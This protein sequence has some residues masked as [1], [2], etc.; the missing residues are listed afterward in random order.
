MPRLTRAALRSQELKEDPASIPLPVTPTKG[1]VPLK[2]TAGNTSAEPET[3]EESEDITAATETGPRKSKKGNVTKKAIKHQP[4]KDKER[5]VD[6]LEDDNISDISSA[7]EEAC[8]DL[9]EETPSTLDLT[10][11]HIASAS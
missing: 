1:R 7:A 10:P 9:L 2:E 3:V 4:S 11:P 5:A 8:K 6:V